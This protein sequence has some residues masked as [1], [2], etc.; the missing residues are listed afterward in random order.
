MTKRNNKQKMRGLYTWKEVQ[1]INGLTKR[2]IYRAAQESGAF[3]LFDDTML[4]TDEDVAIVRDHCSWPKNKPGHWVTFGCGRTQGFDSHSAWVPDTDDLWGAVQGVV[5]RLPKELRD[6]G[7]IGTIPCTYGQYLEHM[8]ALRR[9]QNRGVWHKTSAG[10]FEYID[11]V[12]AK[13]CLAR[14]DIEPQAPA[15]NGS[16]TTQVAASASGASLLLQ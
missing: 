9:Y 14:S 5:A 3:R 13:V 12:C 1:R 4:F 2:Q 6:E 11:R 8:D 15:M 16:A 7:D 10:Y